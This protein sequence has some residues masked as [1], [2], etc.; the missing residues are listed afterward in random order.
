[1]EC[2]KIQ[3][4]SI[5]NENARSG[6]G[7]LLKILRGNREAIADISDSWQEYIASIAF[8][9]VPFQLSTYKDVAPLYEEA[10]QFGF[11]IDNTLPSE[12]A[13][14]GLFTCDLPRVPIP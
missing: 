14:S 6:L 9:L 4:A 5:R 13:S 12:I 7:T 8:F 1:M 10:V 11:M 2:R 3:I